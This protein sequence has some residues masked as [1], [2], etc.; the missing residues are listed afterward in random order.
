MKKVILTFVVLL[1]TITASADEIAVT[2]DGILYYLSL[3]Y[4]TASASNGSGFEGKELHLPSTIDYEG[5][6][7]SLSSVSARAFK[8]CKSI[9]KIV[10]PDGVSSIGMEAFNGCSGL[11]TIVI[12]RTLNKLYSY[13]TFA[14]CSSLEEISFPDLFGE[15]NI[16]GDDTYGRY[17]WQKGRLNRTFQGCT[18]LK[19]VTFGLSGKVQ[20]PSWFSS[21]QGFDGCESLQKLVLLFRT[22]DAVILLPDD[23]YSKI[24]LVVPDNSV[25]AFRKAEG[26]NRFGKIIS[27]TENAQNGISALF[28]D[29]MRYT[30]THDNHTLTISGNGPVLECG[31]QGYYHNSVYFKTGYLYAPWESIKHLIQ[32]V[33]IEDGVTRIEK[34]AFQDNDGLQ[35]VTIGHTVT[36]I[37]ESAFQNCKGLTALNIPANVATI[38]D[39]AFLGCLGLKTIQVEDGNPTYDSRQDCNALIETATNTLLYGCSSTV[40]PDGVKIIAPYAFFCTGIT[41][42]DLPASVT[43]IGESAFYECRQL[44]SVSIPEGVAEISK[45]AFYGCNGMTKLTIN[46]GVSV[47]GYEAF[48]NCSNLKEVKIPGS[49]KTIEERAF[50]ECSNLSKL[51]I[52]NGVESIAGGAFYYCTSLTSVTLP[53]SV[54]KTG[55]LFNGCISLTNVQLSEGLTALSSFFFNDCVRLKTII[56]PK[57]VTRLEGNLFKGCTSLSSITCLNPQPPTCDSNTFE[58]VDFTI[59]LY[60]PKGSVLKY[61]AAEQWRYFVVVREVSEGEDQDTWLTINDGAHGSM[62][63]KIDTELP[64][65]TLRFTPEDG[66]YIY[67]VMLDEEDV[68]AELSEDGTYT[69]PAITANSRLSVIY[70]D[71]STG[72]AKVQSDTRYEVRPTTNGLSLSGL[73]AGD[74][75]SVYT[76]NGQ[77][78]YNAQAT[79]SQAE[80]PLT[81]HQVYIVKVN[82]QT[83][84]VCL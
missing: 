45:H 75:I 63:L 50:Y 42:A 80:I 83:L 48:M 41:N 57:S 59:P 46:K 76:P 19:T 1:T 13:M 61:K 81:L 84:K 22:P 62:S 10:I 18:N 6:T 14:G 52:E 34:G 77:C 35:S 20:N 43:T 69:T 39:G 68:T 15:E 49:V 47:I 78:V 66:W 73:T 70:A 79:G 21:A 55:G 2:I 54:T 74:R 25:E 26:W 16:I 17:M 8:D 44:N 24:T 72:M 67:S 51:A 53:N 32:H 40:V 82:N 56:I 36:E 64:Y 3:D 5:R 9:E 58:G 71:S 23:L 31:Q 28:G 33:V 11:K 65:L 30:Y 12:P 27:V 4:G 37:G 60:V 29:D 7:Y 38:R